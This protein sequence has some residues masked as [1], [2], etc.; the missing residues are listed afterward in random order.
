MRARFIGNGDADPA[1]LTWGG[2]TFVR[3]EA[4]E[5][6]PELEA[7]IRGNS[8]FEVVRGRPP[9]AKEAKAEPAAGP[10]PDD[11]SGID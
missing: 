7:K 11:W 8:H 10:E 4:V 2:V 1:S 5:V 3:G 6:P 9:K